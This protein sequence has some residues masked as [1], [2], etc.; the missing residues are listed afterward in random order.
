MQNMYRERSHISIC[1]MARAYRSD[2]TS[3]QHFLNFPC[4]KDRQ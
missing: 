1:V 2:E 3:K 4:G